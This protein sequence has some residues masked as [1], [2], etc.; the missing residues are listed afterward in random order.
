MK[1]IHMKTATFFILSVIL[2]SFQ[3]SLAQQ[4]QSHW[5]VGQWE[6]GI[7]RYTGKDGPGRTLRVI[8]VSPDGSAEARWAVTGQTLGSAE[9]EVNGP[10]VKV[11][12]GANSVVELTQRSGDLLVGWFTLRTGRSFPIS[13]AKTITQIKYRLSRHLALGDGRSREDKA[14]NS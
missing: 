14:E 3:P 12:T 1:G 6:G 5:L 9:A 7:D 2:F 11:V 8:S 4:P 13:L 10:R